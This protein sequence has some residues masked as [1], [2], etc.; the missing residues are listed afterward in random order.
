MLAGGNTQRLEAL[1]EGL[2]KEVQRLQALTQDGNREARRTA[3]ATN[4]TPPAFLRNN[5]TSTAPRST[6]PVSRAG[7]TCRTTGPVGGIVCG[8]GSVAVSSVSVVM[9]QSS[10]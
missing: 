10:G 2:T 4:G 6:P 1:V 5:A 9:V 7:K 8:A 3:D